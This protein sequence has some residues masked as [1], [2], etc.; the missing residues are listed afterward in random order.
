[1]SLPR[2]PIAFDPSKIQAHLQ[3]LAAAA[4]SLNELSD[5]LTREIAEIESTLNK[6]NVGITACVDVESWADEEGLV[7]NTWRLAYMKEAG[8]WGF[9]IEHLNGH[10]H[11]PEDDDYEKWLFKDAPREHRLRA[12]ENI[13]LL[14]EELVKRSKTVASD[15]TGKVSYAKS[16]AASF[17]AAVL[18]KPGASS[19]FSH[20]DLKK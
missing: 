3:E 10:H 14:L 6:L 7:W 19:Q 5:Q 12:I 4:H 18:K 15:I 1:M 9:V 13:P 20:D 17:S 11:F 16:L 8:K 2:N